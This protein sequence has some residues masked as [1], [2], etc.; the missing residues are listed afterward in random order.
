MLLCSAHKAFG[1][2]SIQLRQKN[3]RWFTSPQNISPSRSYFDRS[4]I[5]RKDSQWLHN[6]YGHQN[7]RFLP[8]HQLKIL[9]AK[10]HGKIGLCWLTRDQLTEQT[11]ADTKYDYRESSILLGTMSDAPYFVCDV[12][13]Q[14]PDLFQMHGR[15]DDARSLLM[16]LSDAN[17]ANIISQARSLMEWKQSHGFCSN[18]GSSTLSAEG[19]T[20]RKCTNTNCNTE[21]YPRINPVAIVLI[22]HGDSCLLARQPKF[23]QGVYSCIAGFMEPAESLEDCVRREVYEETGL[24][25]EKIRYHSSQGW[26]FPSQLMIGCIAT[27]TDMNVRIDN[28]ELEDGQW[29][30]RDQVLLGL[31]RSRDPRSTEFRVPPSIAIAHQLIK[32]W[33]LQTS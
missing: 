31:E 4:S 2:L 25:V 28:D 15:F 1:R 24:S 27:S 19:G 9:S 22:T 18:C 7:A 14:S 5:L 20:K 6:Q 33:A 26:P 13:K 17:D 23:P 3:A 12:S 16:R 21:H 29:F 30:N 10:N 32:A 8:M 11:K